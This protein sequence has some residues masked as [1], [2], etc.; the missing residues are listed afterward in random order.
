MV[1]VVCACRIPCLPTM[2]PTCMSH[3]GR[4]QSPSSS[5]ALQRAN[6][7]PV[8]PY[9]PSGRMRR[10]ETT[11]LPRTHTPRFSA[12]LSGRHDIRP[13]WEILNSAQ[14][15]GWVECRLHCEETGLYLAPRTEPEHSPQY[16]LLVDTRHTRRQGAQLRACG[17]IIYTHRHRPRPFV[18]SYLCGPV[19]RIQFSLL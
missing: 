11:K 8:L 6:V 1:S 13:L 4:A 9:H 18:D 15:V 16:T 2:R 10:G 14:R 17:I 3:R 19:S 5:S 7:S 12:A